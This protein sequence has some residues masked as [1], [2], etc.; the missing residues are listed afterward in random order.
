SDFRFELFLV[1]GTAESTGV[2]ELQTDQEIVGLSHRRAVGFQTR[3][4]K[5]PRAFFGALH[6][7]IDHTD[8]VRIGATITLNRKCLTPPDQFT[9]T[10]PEVFPSPNRMLARLT[11]GRAVPA[12]HRVYTPSIADDKTADIDRLRHRAPLRRG[13]YRI[14]QREARAQRRNVRAERRDV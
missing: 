9:T 7:V 5:N 2:G 11:R 10:P 1:V 3:V 4:E 13:Q 12:F 6:V 14:V 8:L